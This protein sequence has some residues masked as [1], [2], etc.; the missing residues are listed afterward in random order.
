MRWLLL[1]LL[2]VS[3]PGLAHEVRPGYIEIIETLPEDYD[4]SWK[5]PIR[6]SGQQ[7]AGL[8]LRPVF[9]PNCMRKSDSAFITRPGALVE[10]FSLNC[11]GGLGGQVIAIEG[12]QK[13]ITDVFVRL[14]PLAGQAVNVRLTAT[15]P[16]Q[17]LAGGGLAFGAY[18]GLGVRHLLGGFDHILFVIGLVL[19]VSGWRRLFWVVTAFTLAHSLTLALSMLEIFRLPSAPVEA[20]IALSILFVAI[21]L[22]H[23]P[24]LRSPIASRFPQA[25]AFGFGL[26]HGFGFAG[27]LYDIGLPRGATIEALALFNIGLEAG[28]LALVAL[29]LAVGGVFRHWRLVKF[30]G[31]VTGEAAPLLLGVAACY[32]LVARIGGIVDFSL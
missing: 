25:I 21:E 16:A 29:L 11:A 14:V 17:K 26:L 32:W 20:M 3:V 28:Q 2:C 1:L 6:P 8:G 22:T 13:T 12:L 5:Q 23:A 27:V 10:S 31:F 24:D 19:L 9:P 4:I 30:G 15:I 18:F 7:V